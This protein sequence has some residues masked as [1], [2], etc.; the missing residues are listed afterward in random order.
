MISIIHTPTNSLNNSVNF[1]T[2]LGYQRMSVEPCLFRDGDAIIEVNQ[3]R[4]ARAG[5]KLVRESWE[6]RL[7]ALDDV[8][9]LI[10]TKDGVMFSDPS[11]VWIYLSMEG[12]PFAI[13]KSKVTQSILGNFAGISIETG[14]FQRSL[15]VYEAL[16]F[17]VS[18]GTVEQGFVSLSCEGSCPV[19]L[20][21][22]LSCPHLFFNPSMTYFNGGNNPAVIENIRRTGIPIAE[23]ITHFNKEGL[24][25]NVILRDPGGY[26]IFVFN[27]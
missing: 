21:Q 13:P 9:N 27:D 16:G 2:A 22:P 8:V 15:K 17:S 5:I 18:S 10:T 4:Y 7:S 26:G 11:G 12:L 19:S 3:D 25:D 23:E 14:D 24:V 6:D 1:Y 20:M